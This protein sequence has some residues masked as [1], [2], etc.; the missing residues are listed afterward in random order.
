VGEKRK[1]YNILSED[2]KGR[3]LVVDMRMILKCNSRK[4][5]VMLWLD[6]T[7][8]GWGP[9]VNTIKLPVPLQMMDLLSM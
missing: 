6:S 8:A 2:L 4:E 5:C 1:A 7:E 3:N 9:F